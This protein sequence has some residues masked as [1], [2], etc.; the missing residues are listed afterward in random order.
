MNELKARL[1]IEKISGGTN[2]QYRYIKMKN[3]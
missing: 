2:Q 1:I 3:K